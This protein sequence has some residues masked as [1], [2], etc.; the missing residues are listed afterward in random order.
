[1]QV[2]V[3]VGQARGDP[4]APQQRLEAALQVV[5]LLPA[6]VVGVAAVP[7]VL[8]VFGIAEHRSGNKQGFFCKQLRSCRKE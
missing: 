3:A 1:M 4:R 8:P 5:L 6:E 2:F 7:R